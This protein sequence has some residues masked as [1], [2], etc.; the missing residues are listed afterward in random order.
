[1]AKIFITGINGFVGSHLLKEY[2]DDEVFGLVKSGTDDSGLGEDVTTFRGDI[3]DQ[4]GMKKIIGDIRPD[5]VFHLAALT[6]PAESLKNPTDTINNNIQGQINILEAL[7]QN[8][9]F[10]TKNLVVSSAEVYGDV[11]E[12]DLPISEET[13]L[14]PNTPYAVSKVAQDFL[15][16]QYFI[17]YGIKSIRVRPFNHIGPGQAPVFV[18]STFAKQI[19]LIEKGRQEKKIKVGNLETK[20]D[21][22]DVRDVVRAYRLLMEKGKEG[23][24]YNIGSGI[25]Y[26]I[27][28]VLDAL[29]SF[30]T[31]HIEIE[32][33][34]ELIR[35]TDI[36]ELR[37]DISKIHNLT[38][39]SPEIKLEQSLRDTLDYWRNNV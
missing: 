21:F 15:G 9:L 22:T 37:C 28:D 31:E 2:K 23:D 26:K 3:L 6:S 25:S 39:W 34:E 20:R 35:Q 30:S 14:L 24:V 8:T 11:S 17:A 38:G 7:R 18:V 13:M 4:E 27:S 5:I 16:Y 32:R 29:L 33:D 36:K 19:A 1:M 12:K 10:G